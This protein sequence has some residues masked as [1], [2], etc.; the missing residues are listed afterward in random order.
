MTEDEEPINDQS[1]S[2]NRELLL[3]YAA[4]L[5]RRGIPVFPT[6]SVTQIDGEWRCTCGLPTG[7]GTGFCNRPGKHPAT[8]SGFYDAST[9]LQQVSLWFNTDHTVRNL[10][11]ATGQPIIAIDVDPRHGGIDTLN[12]WESWTNGIEL[13]VTRTTRTGS[14]GLHLMY[15]VPEG[16]RIPS[17]NSI[18]PGIDVKGVNGYIVTAPSRHISGHNYFIENIDQ[19]FAPASAGLITWLLELTHRRRP[20]SSRGIHNAHRDNNHIA[21]STSG[22]EENQQGGEERIAVGEGN[23]A[24]G[25]EGSREEGNRLEIPDDYDFHRGGRAGQRDAYLNDVAFRLRVRGVSWSEAQDR[26]RIE[27]EH[28][29]QPENDFFP[30]E[31]ALYKLE[32]VWSTVQPDPELS[33]ATQ[34][35]WPGVLTP[36]LPTQPVVDTGGS[37][38]ESEPESERS[39]RSTAG[40]DAD[41]TD[42]NPELSSR[43]GTRIINEPPSFINDLTQVGL[44]HRFINMFTNKCLFVP[45]IGWHIWTGIRWQLDELND[46][47]DATQQLLP[48]LRREQE[49]AVDEDRQRALARLY[50]TASSLQTRRAILSGASADPRMKCRVR[51]L[52]SD[53]FLLVVRNGTL[54]L[55]TGKLRASKPEDRNT[56]QADVVYDPT[57]ESPLWRDHMNMISRK[58]N[59][60]QPDNTWIAYIQR[61]MGY[62]LTG[63]VAEQRFF[64][65]F[66]DGNNGKNVMIETLMEL[67]GDYA[68]RASPKLVVGSNSEHET[69]IADLAGYR[70][71]FVDEVPYEKLND[72]RLKDLSGS[73]RIRAR[74]VVEKSFEFNMRAK[75]WLSANKKP[76]VTD[77]SEGFWRRID[78]VPFDNIIEKNRRRKDFGEILSAER[79]GILNWILAG[80]HDYLS[81][82]ST[83]LGTPSR[84]AEASQ[85][86]RDTENTFQHFLSENFDIEAHT[87]QWDWQPNFVIHSVYT[88]WMEMQGVAK[89]PTMQHIASDLER[90][91][92]VRDTKTHRITMEF[93]G[94]SRVQRGWI[95]PPMLVELPPAL[96]WCP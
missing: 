41:S 83:G 20:S 82:E 26:L 67:M 77:N 14:N 94:K 22:G 72:S 66:G 54:D 73:K 36:A 76:H 29:D 44:T 19:D 87:D 25:E 7:N 23:G 90:A 27:W 4:D 95:A 92:F 9:S 28:L 61:W 79:S 45:G 2:V 64:F 58:K 1:S 39:E 34:M 24:L 46:V 62:T 71:V 55:R 85:A 48:L 32:R 78:L 69:I 35:A 37:R 63:S 21:G 50:D 75:L 49:E 51:D 60:T 65:G 74:H 57:A 47:L 12:A 53:P 91:G 17:R 11:I 56:K 84:V 10:A 5:I 93:G 81:S 30:W 18:L 16:V 88:T 8:R 38:M 15:T 6:H 13:P 31:S 40:A 52:D 43:V 68:M 96:K 33:R 42:A 59:A 80:L 86:Y 89:V 70:M 3:E